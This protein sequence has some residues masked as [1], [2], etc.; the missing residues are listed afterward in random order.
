MTESAD[1]R[2]LNAVLYTTAMENYAAELRRQF[3]HE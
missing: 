3:H 1:V 2:F